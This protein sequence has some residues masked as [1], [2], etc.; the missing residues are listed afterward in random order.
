M[1]KE[2]IPARVRTRI[3]RKK[4]ALAENKWTEDGRVSV[5]ERALLQ[6]IN[7]CL[8]PGRVLKRTRD[9]TQA[10]FELGAYF[11]LDTTRNVA[12]QWRVDI[13]ALARELHALEDF[14]AVRYRPE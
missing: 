8:P 1:T 11:V 9:G 10:S 5:S 2:K 13:A 14:E 3:Q 6:R 12:V 7:R 4:Q